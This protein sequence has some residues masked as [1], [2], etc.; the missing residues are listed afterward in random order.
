MIADSPVKKL[1]VW[2]KHYL[3]LLIQL[4]LI[5]LLPSGLPECVPNGPYGIRNGGHLL[6]VYWSSPRANYP[7]LKI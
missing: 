2:F 5:L 7:C 4:T 6:H 3:H 1:V